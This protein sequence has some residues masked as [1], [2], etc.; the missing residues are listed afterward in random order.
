MKHGHRLTTCKGEWKHVSLKNAVAILPG[1]K[2][3]KKEGSKKET[4]RTVRGP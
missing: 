1:I 3:P 4:A 2:Y